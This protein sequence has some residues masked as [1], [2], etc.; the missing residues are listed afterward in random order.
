LQGE[1]SLIP[2][3]QLGQYEDVETGLYYNRFRYYSPE[4]GTYISQDPIGLAGGMAFYGYVH[5]S[6]SWVDPFG[7]AELFDLGTYGSLN[8]TSNVGDNLQAHELIRHEYLH[9]QGLATKGGRLSG[10]PSIALDNAHHTKTGGAHWHEAQ[11]RKSQGLGKNQFHSSFKRELDITQ[12]G[13]RKAGI[14]ASLARKL[15]KQSE[16]F[17]KNLKKTCK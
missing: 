2:F 6:N 12:G 10:N 17:Y 11:I 5:D 8:G 1:R 9:Q 14:P 7:L 13:L 16:K 3:R 4:T 15:R